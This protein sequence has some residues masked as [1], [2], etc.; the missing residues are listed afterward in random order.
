MLTKK[1]VALIFRCLTCISEFPGCMEQ[2]LCGYGRR[3]HSATRGMG[4]STPCTPQRVKWAH[5]PSACR[6]PRAQATFHLSL[7]PKDVCRDNKWKPILQTTWGT[8]PQN[9]MIEKDDNAHNNITS[10]VSTELDWRELMTEQKMY[11]ETL[12]MLQINDY[13]CT[14]TASTARFWSLRSASGVFFAISISSWVLW[15]TKRGL[16]CH[17]NTTFLPVGITWKIWVLS[18]EYSTPSVLQRNNTLALGDAKKSV[19]QSQ[20][21]IPVNYRLW[22]R[23]SLW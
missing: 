14:H 3:H 4:R 1:Q 19:V 18:E 21:T 12:A 5:S 2:G 8:Y 13:H 15:R 6:Y 11:L 7:D 16:P 20:T 10:A 22:R 9:Q 17:F 23:W